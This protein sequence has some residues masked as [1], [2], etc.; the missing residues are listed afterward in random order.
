MSQIIFKFDDNTLCPTWSAGDKNC[1][2]FHYTKLN[3]LNPGL[4]CRAKAIFVEI[5]F[6]LSISLYRGNFVFILRVDNR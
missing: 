1:V 5:D 6:S 3:K 2:A 4:Y